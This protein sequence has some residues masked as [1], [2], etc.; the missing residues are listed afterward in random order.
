MN[1]Q[2][3]RNWSIG[4]SLLMLVSLAAPIAAQTPPPSSAG[5]WTIQSNDVTVISANSS[6][7]GQILMQGDINIYGDL[8]LDGMTVYMWG[9]SNGHREIQIFN[10]GSLE[11]KNGAQILPYNAAYCYDFTTDAG[12]EITMT[13]TIIDRACQV[14][15]DSH[16]FEFDHLT[17]KNSQGDALDIRTSVNVNSSIQNITL[18]NTGGSNGIYVSYPILTNS[19]YCYCNLSLGDSEFYWEGQSYTIETPKI[20][21]NNVSNGMIRYY[22]SYGTDKVDTFEIS[23]IYCTLNSCDDGIFLSNDAMTI[24]IETQYIFDN[25][26]LRDRMYVSIDHGPNTSFNDITINHA[27]GQNEAF[28]L[29]RLLGNSTVHLSNITLSLAQSSTY[30]GLKINNIN[31]DL[32]FSNLDVQGFAYDQVEITSNPCSTCTITFQNSTISNGSSNNEW[33]IQSS[34]NVKIILDN[35]TVSGNAQNNQ[36]SAT[37]SYGGVYSNNLEIINSNISD[38]YHFS[39]SSSYG[40][41]SIHKI[42][43]FGVRS[44]TLIVKNSTISD[45]CNRDL[46][47]YS[48]TTNNNYNTWHW[49]C[50]GSSNELGNQYC[51]RIDAFGIS[52]TNVQITNSSI[53]NN[54]KISIIDATNSGS[55]ESYRNVYVRN[56]GLLASDG[57]LIID[58]STVVDNSESVSGSYTTY[59]TWYGMI[60]RN[61]NIAII[62]SST[63]SYINESVVTGAACSNGGY[64]YNRCQ[65]TYNLYVENAKNV[66][67]INSLTDNSEEVDGTGGIY[68]YWNVDVDVYDLDNQST[69]NAT[70][71][72]KESNGFAI[73][74]QNTGSGGTVRF[75]VKE[76]YEDA[77]SKTYFTPHNLSISV[78]GFSN[79]TTV[80]INSGT[81]GNQR[82]NR[83]V[84]MY[85]GAPDA[86][87]GDVSQDVDTDGDGYG[88]NQTGTTPDRFINDST[89]WFDVDG[90][91]YGDNINGNNPDHFINDST[92]WNDT[93][94]DGYGDNQSGNNP[95]RLPNDSTQWHDADGDGY[96]DNQ[97]GNNPDRLPNDSTQ[98]ND[99][100]GDGYGD[101]QSGNNPD[102]FVNDSTQWNDYDSDGHGD[103]L[104]G[105]SPDQFP[106]DATQWF[107]GDGDGLGDNQSGNNPD[108]YL[109]DTDNDGYNNTVDVFPGNPTQWIDADGDGLGDNQSGTNPD[110]YLEDSDNDGTNNSL[111]PFPNDPTQWADGDSDGLGDNQSGTNPD[112]SLD[113]SDNDGYNNSVDDFPWIASQWLDSDGDGWGDNP[114]GL[115]ADDFPNDPS[116]WLDVDGDGRGD[117]PN[118]NNSDSFPNDPTQWDDY[119]G[120]GHGDNPN[121]TMPDQFPYDASQW[122]DVDGDGYGDN[123]SWSV[124]STT[125]LREQNGDA[126]PSQVSQ[127]SDLDGD[128]Y[129]DNSSGFQADRY[130]YDYTQWQDSDND[131]FPDNYS[132]TVNQTSGLRENQIGDAFPNDPTQGSDIDGDGYGDNQSGNNA[133]VFPYDPTQWA[134]ADLDGLGDNPNGTNPDPTPGDSDNDGVPDY[135]D[136]F[137]YEPTQWS[138]SDNDGYGDNWGA[139]AWT[140]LRSAGL[141]GMFIQNAVQVDYFPT[142]AAAANDTDFDGYPD[143]WTAMDTGN[144][145][146]GLELDVC[147]LVFGNATTADPGCPDSDGDGFADINDPFPNDPTQST[148]QDGDGYGDNPNGSFP[149]AFPENS[150]QWIDA[151]GDGYGD[152]PA[153]EP[154][155]AFPNDATQW[156]DA[157]GDGYGDNASGL[158]ADQFPNDSTQWQDADGDGLGDDPNGNNSD[159]YVGDTDNDAYPNEQ[160]DCPLTYGN[161][162]YDV[163]GCLDTDGDG[164]SDEGDMWP[165]D[166]SRSLDTDGD[167]WNDPVDAFPLDETQWLD[168]DGDGLGDNPNG[169]NSDPSLDDTDN[170]GVVN[171]N[172]PFPNDATQFQDLD[173]D[174]Y[175][176]NQSGLN[177][178]PYPNDTDNDGV[179]NPEDLYPLDPLQS[180]DSD[181]DGW[182]DNSWSLGGDQFPNDP[183]QCCDTDGD[184]WGDNPNGSMPDAYP[185]DPSQWM[186]ADRD[187]LGD[188]PNGTNPD[189]Y[190]GD[191]DNDG[192]PN[193]ADSFPEDPT[194]ALD[195]DG[196]GIADNDENFYLAQIPETNTSVVFTLVLMAAFIA[197]GAGYLAGS[198]KFGDRSTNQKQFNFSEDEDSEQ[199]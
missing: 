64:S 10:G 159:P 84:I 78:N 51:F 114:T 192:V 65:P 165:N 182:G 183:T 162:S 86:F 2:V 73:G 116:Q 124:N 1:A 187:G 61:R 152:N 74:S 119:D 127:W 69:P 147:A 193:N 59:S 90:D 149:D 62:D 150:E 110:P 30:E 54:S 57:G 38:N 140:I 174:G 33:G 19:T 81:T 17:I 46:S 20:L 186:D 91:G 36:M 9:T 194:K 143:D 178:D 157:D 29:D 128:G 35:T 97:S 104:N 102:R 50:S 6:N 98:W 72:L 27:G 134:D 131:G 85:D 126:F 141:P 77:S 136:A 41:L 70:V 55:R 146:N 67:L 5:D 25:I 32:I 92:Q 158:N 60:M 79:S 151:D 139:T 96:G 120:D 18:Q 137:P 196:D 123:Y 122:L 176:E 138:D 163:R 56:F 48:T 113:D 39:S 12:G 80:S 197:G 49:S 107:D 89:Q 88:D 161:S 132:Y 4:L 95:D 185:L 121:G 99:A 47:V 53:T 180:S 129:G 168:A 66:N 100:D 58:D 188:N 155:D 3:K 108:P 82:G 15:V 23:D 198:K 7:S 71:V 171:Q 184:G 154:F 68:R 145:R 94:G 173:G 26:S 43:C 170:D 34:S 11:L 112:P 21:I 190:P 83:V 169:N 63:N 142:I 118:G 40:G 189:P 31:S 109:N 191:T 28:Y 22:G 93:D 44:N 160:D 42:Q 37:K 199:L 148:D 133:D 179:Q 166:P 164:V 87:P 177:P 156:Y 52:G 24:S 167:G 153:S 111:D 14:D 76:Y 45:N 195:T 115:L 106:Y 16:L 135:L 181:G 130:P 125:G 8:T 103:N 175:G 144:N 105:T 117:N 13:D 172:D 101:N 75:V